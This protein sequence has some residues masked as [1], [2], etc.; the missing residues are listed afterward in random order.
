MWN[1]ERP[2]QVSPDLTLAVF[3][4]AAIVAAIKSGNL[5]RPCVDTEMCEKH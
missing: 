1:A 4:I 5:L 3:P 2:S